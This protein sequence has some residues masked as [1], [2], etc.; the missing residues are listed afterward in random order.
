M[1]AMTDWTR[2]ANRALVRNLALLLIAL[3][4]VSINAAAQP[5]P[6]QAQA[7]FTEP[8]ISP[9]GSVEQLSERCFTVVGLR[10]IAPW[11][12]ASATAGLVT[13][14]WPTWGQ[15]RSPNFISIWTPRIRS[16]MASSLTCA[17]ITAAL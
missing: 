13:C 8:A 6:P 2:R 15:A 3:T 17:T 11:S 12:R 5:A 4:A 10:T 16:A 1:L 14:I 7:Y 9:D